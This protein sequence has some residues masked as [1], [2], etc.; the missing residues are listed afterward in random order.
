MSI[1]SKTGN[2]L[3]T[4]DGTQAFLLLCDLTLNSRDCGNFDGHL[5]AVL[6]ERARLYQAYNDARKRHDEASA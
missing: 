5:R 3:R 4:G 1:R 6:T 2:D